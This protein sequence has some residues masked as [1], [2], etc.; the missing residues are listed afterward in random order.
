[1]ESMIRKIPHIFFPV[2]AFLLLL[3]LQVSAQDPFDDAVKQ[4]TSDNAKG[5]LQPFV[6]SIGANIN[7][8]LFHSAAIGTGSLHLDLRF[9]GMGTIIGDAEKT[10]EAM[11]PEPFAQTP[12]QTATIFGGTG[13]VVVDDP[14]DPL[15][16]YQF[17]NGQVSTTFIPFLAPQLTIGDVF[18]TRATIRYVATPEMNNVP[19]ITLAGGAIQ[20]SIS[21][22][23]PEVPLDLA[24]G[25]FY[26]NIKI[27]DLLEAKSYGLNIM[28]GKS[29]SVLTVYGGLQYESTSLTLTYTY[30]G[31]PI[32][33]MPENPSLS[34]D[35]SGEEKFRGTVGLDLN[36]VILDLNGDIS[37]GKV[38]T[39]SVGIGFGF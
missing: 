23:L 30:T 35:L 31:Q 32:P 4:L 15:V 6:N 10:F 20:H 1:M 27:G 21:R 24:A 17:Q 3:N 2:V 37:V 9:V 25:V 38:T 36:L 28:A 26:Q 16:S 19:K 11:P 29:F 8:G 12:V 7:S 34:V 39:A 5:Y 13:A 33:G 14:N 22:Y 18:G